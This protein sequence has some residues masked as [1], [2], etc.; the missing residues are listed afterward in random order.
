MKRNPRGW[1]VGAV[2]GLALVTGVA[3]QDDKPSGTVQMESTSVAVGIGVSWGDGTLT[4]GGNQHKFS[5]S[6]LSV[7]DLGISKVT[8]KGEVFN[9][10]KLE[11]FSGNYVAAQAAGTLGG[12]AGVV[13][14]RNQ[15]GVVIKLTSTSTGV[16]LTLAGEGVNVKLK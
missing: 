12:G 13:A 16:Q 4:Y 5:V 7:I 6:G 10:K 8:A 9:L 2:I 11:D 1:V 3:A 15:N 14:M